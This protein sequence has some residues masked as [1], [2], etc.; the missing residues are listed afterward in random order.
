MFA[1]GHLL[2]I[3]HEPPKSGETERIGR[4]FWRN[5]EGE[6]RSKN[7]GEGPQ[8]IKRHVAELALRVANL[9]EQSSDAELAADFYTL[10]RKLA[11]LHR[12]IRNLY[13]TLQEAR[14]LVPDDRDLINLRDQVGEIERAVELLHG[15]IK[16]GLEFTIAFQAEQQTERT[17]DMA[18]AGYRLNLLAAAFFPVVTLGAVFGMNLAHGLDRWSTP[19]NFWTLLGL[20][21]ASGLGLAWLVG[22]KPVPADS[23]MAR[24]PATR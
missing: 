13:G 21:L 7:L 6:W 9:E 19:E 23:P 24:K 2:L 17:H 3:L 14:N 15:D 12:T 10:L 18:V 20:G 1:D 22:R 11:P 16:N 8:A 4:P 5:P